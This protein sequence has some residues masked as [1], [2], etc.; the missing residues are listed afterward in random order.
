MR[1]RV[2]P[3]ACHSRERGNSATSSLL[4][5]RHSREREN[6][7][8]SSLLFA[9]HSREGGNPVTSFFQI[10][11]AGFPREARG[12]DEQRKRGLQSQ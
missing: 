8:T 10:N 12:N 7:V 3:V 9:R 6:P 4:F 5:A 1:D 11:D 2:L